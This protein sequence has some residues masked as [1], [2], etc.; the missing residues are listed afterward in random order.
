MVR[1]VFNAERG[2][3][4][5]A[6]CRLASLTTRPLSHAQLMPSGAAN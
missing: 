2:L 1:W 4:S 3:S 5:G 6:I